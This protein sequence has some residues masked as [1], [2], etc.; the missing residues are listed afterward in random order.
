MRAG[1]REQA[2]LLLAAGTLFTLGGC[3]ARHAAL[4]GE[5]DV[6]QPA[7]QHAAPPPRRPAGSMLDALQLM[8]LLRHMQARVGDVSGAGTAVGEAAFLRFQYR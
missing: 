5:H 2:V 8:P 3:G 1:L 4:R 6:R 7:L